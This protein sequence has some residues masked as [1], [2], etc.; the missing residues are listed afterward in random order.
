MTYVQKTARLII[1]SLSLMGEIKVHPMTLA[2]RRVS[3]NPDTH[4][5]AFFFLINLIQLSLH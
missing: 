2:E 3:Y 1:H 5:Y 4:A